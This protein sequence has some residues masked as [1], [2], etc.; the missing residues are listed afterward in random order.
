MLTDS[1]TVGKGTL[2][3]LRGIVMS[4]NLFKKGD[5]VMYGMN[6]VCLV[7]EIVV[8][9][10]PDGDKRTCYVLKPVSSSDATVYIPVDSPVIGTKVRYVIEKDDID[11]ILSELPGKEMEWQNDKNLR[12]T[13]FKE[14]LNRGLCEDF[15]L[16]L[17][18]IYTRKQ[19]LRE[20]GKKLSSTDESIFQSA[21]RMA[22]EELSYSLRIKED[23][24]GSYI[25][26]KL[27][28]NG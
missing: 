28:I 27:G 1:E 4:D 3:I 6:G 17:N 13:K 18:C 16:M 25:K 10:Y 2:F 24:V 15:L 23:E 26:R 8:K 12:T 21:E 9:D 20:A 14:I 11:K 7:D 19:N 5:Y 22:V